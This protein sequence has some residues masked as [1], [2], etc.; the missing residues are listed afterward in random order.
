[1]KKYKK[2]SYWHRFLIIFLL[3]FPLF[4]ILSGCTKNYYYISFDFNGSYMADKMIDIL[5]RIPE[6]DIK[7][8][9]LNIY[10][11]EK[12]YGYSYSAESEIA[13][14]NVDGYRSICV[15]YSEVK[16]TN[17]IVKDKDGSH[18]N[19]NYDRNSIEYITINIDVGSKA[20]YTRLCNK[21]GTFKIALLDENGSILQ[22]SEEIPFVTKSGFRLDNDIKYD[23]ETNT[24]EENYINDDKTV[25]T[26]CF[27]LLI[28]SQLSSFWATVIAL[29]FIVEERLYREKYWKY[30]LIYGIMS[31][32]AVIL[33]V[34]WYIESVRSTVTQGAALRKF[35][36]LDGGAWL[37][38]L[39]AVPVLIF[40]VFIVLIIIFPQKV[41]DT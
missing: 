41:K 28:L 11:D 37:I 12:Y 30:A 6:D 1:M 4:M 35:L 2:C 10:T 3:I 18:K 22:I 16:G 13:E 32:P 25:S 29:I 19:K 14:Y 15:H 26:I 36:M 23:P 21:Y 17:K 34:L 8:T 9:D 31:V 20:Y 27:A 40:I 24:V 5:V 33:G 39:I 7:Y 38:P